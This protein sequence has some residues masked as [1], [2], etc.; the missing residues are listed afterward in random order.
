MQRGYDVVWLGGPDE[1]ELGGQLA[2][3]TP[4]TYDLTGQTSIPEACALQ[5]A[6]AGNVAVDTGLVH[7]SAATGRPTVTINGAS[8]E[9][10]MYPLGPRSIVLRG[11]FL[12]TG[13]EPRAECEAFGSAAH[14]IHPERVLRVLEALMAEE[15]ECPGAL[16]GAAATTA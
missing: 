10:W 8:P 4:G 15:H 2:A 7:T 1:R 12:P 11:P 9:S 14:R 5:Y 16:A 6:A 3:A 13:G